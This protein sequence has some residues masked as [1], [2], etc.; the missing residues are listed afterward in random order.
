MTP[1]RANNLEKVHSALLVCTHMLPPPSP[2]LFFSCPSS[3]TFLAPLPY[4]LPDPPKTGMALSLS[5]LDGR[6]LQRHLYPA[7]LGD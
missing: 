3:P 7:A 4:C 5:A 1:N 6:Y 2:M